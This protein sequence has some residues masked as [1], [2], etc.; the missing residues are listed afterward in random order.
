M[1]RKSTAPRIEGKSAEWYPSVFSS[2]NGGLEYCADAIPML[3]RHTLEHLRREFSRGELMCMIDV[4]NSTALN[5]VLAGQ[6]LDI[7]VADGI[8][9]DSLDAKWAIDGN[10]LNLKIAGLTIFEA[11]CLEI[12]ANGFWYRQNPEEPLDLEA[13]AG[14][15]L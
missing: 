7:Q 1:A 5:P 6:Q 3:Y 11:A 15:L 9:L 12:W 2:L 13:W 4:F 14:Q 10:A 8:T